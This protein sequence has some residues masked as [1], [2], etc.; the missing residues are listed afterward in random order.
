MHPITGAGMLDV[1]I[2]FPYEMSLFLYI[3]CYDCRFG[4]VYHNIQPRVT[5]TLLHVFLDPSKLLPQHYGAVQGLA[6]LGPSVVNPFSNDLIYY[7]ER[8][9]R[10]YQRSYS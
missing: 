6:D 3:I 9:H 7:E 1:L 4:H 10:I 2:L 5:K 8:C